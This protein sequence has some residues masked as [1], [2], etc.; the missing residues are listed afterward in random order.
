MQ[1]WQRAFG[2]LALGHSKTSLNPLV[3]SS[4]PQ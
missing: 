2:I 4:W 3:S 1:C